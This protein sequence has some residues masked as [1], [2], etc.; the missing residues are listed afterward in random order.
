MPY[1][2]TAVAAVAALGLVNLLLTL[3]AIRRLR[4]YADLLSTTPGGAGGGV[5]AAGGR[6]AEFA[7]VDTE[8]H[9][10][11]GD[12]PRL[13]GFFSPD[14]EPCKAALPA[15]VTLAAEYPQGRTRVLAVV[16][17]DGP[18]V[19]DFTGDLTRV[20][21]VVVES[22]DGPVSTAFQVSGY[23]AWCSLDEHGV[24][25]RSGVGMDDLPV[26]AAR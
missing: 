24:V 18:G 19:T 16:A 10:V 22:T 11:S 8:G 15:F 6:P 13:M 2:A 1:L 25:Q 17:G 7:A 4:Q 3:A 20:A 12:G 26:P 5:I 9:P 23:P 14:C 21:Q